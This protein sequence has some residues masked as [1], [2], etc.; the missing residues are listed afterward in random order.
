[1]VTN[2]CVE[3]F[4]ILTLRLPQHDGI[5]TCTITS[6]PQSFRSNIEWLGDQIIRKHT[7]AHTH[8]YTGEHTLSWWG[9]VRKATD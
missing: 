1:M 4:C 3:H 5:Y 9:G 7:S 6:A 2:D 8:A